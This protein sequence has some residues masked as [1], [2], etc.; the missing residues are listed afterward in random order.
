MESVLHTEWSINQKGAAILLATV[1]E[2]GINR[3]GQESFVPIDSFGEG[4]NLGWR[5]ARGVHRAND[6]AHAGSGNPVHGNVV[7]FHPLNNAD[8]GQAERT[9]AAESQSNSRTMCGSGRLRNRRSV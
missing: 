5:H 9:P 4:L 2:L 8:F 1:R 6:A 7:L 3:L